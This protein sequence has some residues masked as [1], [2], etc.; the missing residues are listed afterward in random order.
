ML[1]A[2]VGSVAESMYGM[3]NQENEYS[4]LGLLDEYVKILKKV[5]K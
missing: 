3:T 4:I 1:G 5:Y 2:I